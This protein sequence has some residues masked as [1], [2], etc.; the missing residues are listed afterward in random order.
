[1]SRPELDAPAP[2]QGHFAPGY[3]PVARCFARQIESGE[4]TGAGFTVYHR[5]ECVVDL[6]GGLADVES[7]RPWERDTRIVLFSVTK[8]FTAMAMFLLADRGLLDWD[9]PVSKYWPGFAQKGK[10]KIT[11]GML[12]GHRGGLPYLD[13]KL[14]IRDCLDETKAGRV[15]EALEAQKPAW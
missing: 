3:E 5:G 1:M 15:L 8:G 2:A 4:E 12:L 13:K 6:W 14:S 10:A 7:E 9:A 11:V